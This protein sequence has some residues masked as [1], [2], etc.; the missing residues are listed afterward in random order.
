MF[1][2][3]HSLWRFWNLPMVMYVTIY[4]SFIFTVMKFYSILCIYY[5]LFIFFVLI[6]IWVVFTFF[7][8]L[9]VLPGTVWDTWERISLVYCCCMKYIYLYCIY[10]YRREN[11]GLQGLHI[12]PLLGNAN[13][14]HQQWVRIP[15][16]QV[17]VVQHYQHCIAKLL[18]I[19]RYEGNIVSNCGFDLHFFYQ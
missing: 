3:A 19:C 18:N 16:D 15:T 17:P 4:N 6:F 13:L 7:L 10:I 1:C 5:N 12:S 8:L 9:I 14:F 11:P 2:D